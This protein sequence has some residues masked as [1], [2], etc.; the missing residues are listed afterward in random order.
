MSAG[1]VL[2]PGDVC[3]AI[4]AALRALN[5]GVEV[6]HRGG[7]VRV[8]APDRCRITRA[9]VEAELGRPFRLP[10]DL[11]RVM[12]AFQGRFRVDESEAWWVG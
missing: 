6:R 7:Y 1:P 8:S 5:E 12:P 9:A 2:V 11:E 3:E 10:T 4:V